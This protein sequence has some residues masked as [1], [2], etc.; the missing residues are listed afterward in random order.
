MENLDAMD[1]MR[2]AEQFLPTMT[3]KAANF[4]QEY[5]GYLDTLNNSAEGKKMVERAKSYVDSAESEKLQQKITSA[6][7]DV[8]V[9]K[10]AKWGDTLSRDSEARQKFADKV[11]PLLMK[12]YRKCKSC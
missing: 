12:Y 8:N 5:D 11:G 1:L 7:A 4:L 2:K 10:I 6:M 3:V 9:E